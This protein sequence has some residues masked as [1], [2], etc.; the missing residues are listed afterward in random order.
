MPVGV[1]CGCR[2]GIERERL[3][4]GLDFPVEETR[5]QMLEGHDALHRLDVFGGQT[6]AVLLAL[7]GLDRVNDGGTDVL[8]VLVELLKGV[9]SALVDARSDGGCRADGG[10]GGR[11]G[12]GG[13]GRGGVVDMGRRGVIHVGR[14]SVICVV[15]VGRNVAG[16]VVAISQLEALGGMRILS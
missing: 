12:G 14:G 3:G 15:D 10:G 7:L 1:G 13:S 11:S 9:V 2:G 8:D 4:V 16:V 5:G 6:R